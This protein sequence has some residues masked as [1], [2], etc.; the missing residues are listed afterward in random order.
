M[1]IFEYLRPGENQPEW[2]Q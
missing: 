2:V 1:V